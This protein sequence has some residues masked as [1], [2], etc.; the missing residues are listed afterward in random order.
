M[1]RPRCAAE[2]RWLAIGIALALSQTHVLAQGNATGRPSFEVATIKLYD[3]SKN[4]GATA[5]ASWKPST[6]GLE[7]IG[8][9]HTFIKQ[10]YGVEDVQISGGP[11][12]IDGSL[13]EI[14][15][16]ASA[17]VNQAQLKLM[18]QTLLAERF[19]LVI[20]TE[21][22]QLPVY[23][24][25]PAKNGSNLQKAD[26]SIGW[27]SGRTLLRGTADMAQFTS[28]LTSTLGRPVI[29]NTGLKGFYKIDLTWAP[30]DP[31]ADG[32]SIFTAIQEQ[33]GLKLESTRGPVQV[34]VIEHAEKPSEN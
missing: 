20:R 14:H 10:G 30:D 29:D 1:H 25:V 16:K 31:T 9:L 34:L 23:S 12:W 26:R 18:L 28:A 7:T 19:K 27:S 2:F 17:P 21:I 4:V 8:S 13:F 33:L 22:R 6:A 24:L 3:L 15:A 11:N 32:P 5:Y